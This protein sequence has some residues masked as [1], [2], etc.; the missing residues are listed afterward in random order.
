MKTSEKQKQADYILLYT[1]LDKYM[2]SCIK[3]ASLAPRYFLLENINDIVEPF[4]RI[5]TLIQRV[6]WLQD[7]KYISELIEFMSVNGISIE[8]LRW[9]V[10]MFAVQKQ[11]VLNR[12]EKRF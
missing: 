2:R 1:I 12:I 3:D 11:N 9:A 4:Y 5:K 6:E 7:E 8:E 10:D